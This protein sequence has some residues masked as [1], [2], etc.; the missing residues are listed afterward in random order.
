MQRR[1]GEGHGRGG[2]EGEAKGESKG[3]RGID[4]ACESDGVVDMDMSSDEEEG[5][6]VSFIVDAN[7]TDAAYFDPD[8][9][10]EAAAY[11]LFERPCGSSLLGAAS[12]ATAAAAAAAEPSTQSGCFNCESL[13][14]SLRACPR[15]LHQATI[16]KNRA[17]FE[18]A[19]RPATPDDDDGNDDDDNK[20]NPAVGGPTRIAA[21]DA[22][23]TR[24]YGQPPRDF[25]ERFYLLERWRTE[26]LRWL[27]T[28]QP[29]MASTELQR[30]LGVVDAE[31]DELPFLYMML[32]WGYPPGWASSDGTNPLKRLWALYEGDSA[33]IEARPLQGFEDIPQL[34]ETTVEAKGIEAKREAEPKG[35]N[36]VGDASQEGAK[37]ERDV[38][39]KGEVKEEGEI[40]ISDEEDEG[41]RVRRWVNYR[42][43]LFDS[44][45]LPIYN[46]GPCWRLKMDSLAHHGIY[47]FKGHPLPDME[48][49]QRAYTSLSDSRDDLFHTDITRSG[50]W[51]PYKYT[52]SYHTR[53]WD[54][55]DRQQGP[56]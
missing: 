4:E 6:E 21:A 23:A 52:N 31:R 9:S 34:S 53:G 51:D 32:R 44:Y 15:P 22:R 41:K 50:A 46:V 17:F 36:G 45:R 16:R 40:T 27:D 29:G 47:V 28:F 38:I 19:R 56:R 12:S 54:E 33:W 26:R 43:A 3:G 7:P 55:V 8:Q 35:A 5:E 20:S 37:E 25:A 48:L 39:P 42:T 13:E 1:H 30:A 2:G 24:S 49:N 10:L 14:H 18:A 11:H